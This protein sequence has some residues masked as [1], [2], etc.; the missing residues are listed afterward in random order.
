MIAV[1]QLPIFRLSLLMTLLLLL[2]EVAASAT[3]E[4]GEPFDLVGYGADDSCGDVSVAIDSAFVADC[5]NTGDG[6]SPI[7]LLMLV[8]NY[9]CRDT[10]Y[11]YR[12]YYSSCNQLS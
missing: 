6:R 12:G 11:H 4:C 1:T 7:L 8:R 3:V 5:G 9:S 2:L 10:D